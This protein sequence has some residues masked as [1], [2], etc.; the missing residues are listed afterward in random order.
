[1]NEFGIWIKQRGLDF[2]SLYSNRSSSQQGA[3]RGDL[4]GSSGTPI[5]VPEFKK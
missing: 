1:M 5:K 2:T 3:S 4:R